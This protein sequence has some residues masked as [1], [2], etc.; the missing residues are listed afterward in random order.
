MNLT[1][2]RFSDIRFI[3]TLRHCLTTFGG[4]LICRPLCNLWITLSNVHPTSIKV[5]INGKLVENVSFKQSYLIF[6]F[7][8]L[9]SLKDTLRITFIEIREEIK[10]FS[11]LR[12][13]RLVNNSKKSQ[14]FIN[15]IWSDYCPVRS[16][17]SKWFCSVI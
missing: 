9:V 6:G 11:I 5:I 4:R 14:M 2:F 1:I 8:V 13:K 16:E 7:F 12:I 15:N 3:K 10:Y 17:K